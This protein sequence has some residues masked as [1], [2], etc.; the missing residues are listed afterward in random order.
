[1]RAVDGKQ[2]INLEWPKTCFCN[3]TLQASWHTPLLR[4]I[5]ARHGDDTKLLQQFGKLVL[6]AHVTG[7][8]V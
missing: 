8:M 6:I 3:A 5:L 4:K 7:Q 1:M 2:E